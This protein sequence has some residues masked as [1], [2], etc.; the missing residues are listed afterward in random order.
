MCFLHASQFGGKY[1]LNEEFARKID[2]TLLNP[3]ATESDMRIHLD[4]ALKYHFKTVAIGC[5]WIPF[6]Y[7]ILKDSDTGID[8][9]I[10]FPA[11]YNTTEVKVFE[12]I[13]AFAKGASEADILINIGWLKS[14][15]YVDME[16]ELKRFVC[17]AGGK[18]TKVILEVCYLTDQQKRDAVKI[19]KRA[20]ADFVKTSTGFIKNGG[21][22][23]EDVKLL[24]KESGDSLQVKASGGIRSRVLAEEL[25]SLGAARLGASNPHLL[26][27]EG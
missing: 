24:V 11:G 12:T 3:E 23:V 4:N 8:A 1:M 7:N 13:D 21:V 18:T 22:T 2:A 20:G 6:A 10:G 5:A 17:A 15:R 14:G 19:I 9:P 27:E 16:D 26:V 25:L